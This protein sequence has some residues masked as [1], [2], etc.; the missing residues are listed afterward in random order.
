MLRTVPVD[1]PY[2]HSAS[3][4]QRKPSVP[5]RSLLGAIKR[6]FW[7]SES[8]VFRGKYHPDVFGRYEP[9]P[10]TTARHQPVHNEIQQ[11][12]S[13]EQVNL[14]ERKLGEQQVVR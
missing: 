12:Q 11:R 8:F 7:C 13:Q 10:R 14:Y 2:R 6:Y 1:P 4:T 9:P 5:A 3:T